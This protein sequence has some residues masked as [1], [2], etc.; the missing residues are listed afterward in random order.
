M[1]ARDPNKTARNKIIEVLKVQLRVLLPKVLSDTGIGSEASLNA[2]IGSRNDDFFDLKNDVITSQDQF[3]SGWLMGLKQ[4]HN[5][6]NVISDTWLWNKIK[7]HKSTQDYVITFLKRS[8]LKHFEELSKNRP[9]VE[10]AELWIGQQNANYG[11]LVT[12][13]F[14]KGQWEND[15]SEIRAFPKPYWTIGHIM[16]TG[17]AIPG[18]N[19]K[20][21]FKDIEQFLIFFQETIVRNSGSQYEYELA[22]L[23]CD[24][25]R[26]SKTPEFIPLMIPEFRYAGLVAKHMYR[27]DFMIINPY[28]LDK[29]G[30]ELSPWSSHGYLKKIKGLTQTRINEMASDNFEKEM[31]KHR[32]YLK[33]HG[34]FCLIYTDES[35]RD[36]KSLFETEITPFLSPEIPQSLISFELLS[37]F[38]I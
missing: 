4:S 26:A 34:V 35:L 16:H 28:T 31:R 13:R 6:G 8:F 38:G 7:S 15:K 3:V 9:L 32:A 29:V 11:I 30:F 19:S 20:F 10:D 22:G 21:E 36:I 12:P 24:F 37:E 14:T 18:K 27:L 23:Y 33:E 25:V 2:Y 5:H 17:L 1:A